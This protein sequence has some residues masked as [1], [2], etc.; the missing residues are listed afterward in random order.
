MMHLM[1]RI[2]ER[3]R[4]CSVALALAATASLLMLTAAA[5]AATI[6]V[7]N[8]AELEAAVTTA[9][10]NAQ[11]N[12]IELA[13]GS[14]L[15]GK[16]LVLTDT[17][18]TQT[19]AGPAGTV[20]VATASA[21]LNGGNVAPVSGVSEQEFFAVKAG[22]TLLLK[23]VV[24]TTAGGG[25]SPAIDDFGTM[26]VEN[27]T[28]DGNTGTQILVESGATANLTNS[29][30]SDGHELGLADEGTA[31]LLNVTA[32]KNTGGGVGGSGTLTLKNS[33]VALNGT[34]AQCGTETITNDHSLSSDA[35]CGGE[36]QFQ[37]KTP[38][39]QSLLQ[40]DGGSTTLYSE[41]AGSPTIDAGD[42]AACPTTDQRGY[43][44]PDA[45]G[46]SAPCDIGADEYSAE[47]PSIKVPAEIVKPATSSA[48]AE[49]TYAVEATDAGSLVKT[50]T[51]TPASGSTFKAGTT[52][53][54]CNAVDGHENKSTASFNVKVT[55]P[56]HLLTV[57]VT[58]E[59]TVTSTPAGIECGQTHTTCSAEFEEVPVTLTPAP[60]TGYTVAWSG[61]CSGTGSCSF[62]PMTAAE[63]V[64]ATFNAGPVNTSVPVISGSPYN[65]QTLK[66]TNGT[67]T[68]SPT[69]F[70]YQWEDCNETGAECSSIAGAN[71]VEYTLTSA[72]IGHT[73]RV[74][75][76]AINSGGE[77]TPAESA[78]TAVV[79]ASVAPTVEGKVPFTQTLASTCSTVVVGPFIPGKPAE[80]AN[81]CGLTATS[82]A[83][84]SKLV[85]E[86]TSATDTGHLV[87]VYSHGPFKETYEL[88]DALEANA[89]STQGG[90][91]GAL[92]S[93]EHPVTLLTYAKPFAEDAV[94]VK[95]NQKI[96][97]H[98]H[99]H[100]GTYAKTIV[101]TLST[102]TP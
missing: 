24:L 2:L 58:G 73:V 99:L 80:Y 89:T 54:A 14:Y 84:E 11:A 31:T 45:F 3:R 52:K 56:K 8:T 90:A 79:T 41:K 55:T 46:G 70:K 38:L 23:H 92:T 17:S 95:F 59:G 1:H 13:S 39:L 87:Q 67:W 77:S 48:G 21:V 74:L 16:S 64:T 93:L 43:P 12:T 33:I 44:R 96:G 42:P 53:V 37:N 100:T 101:V 27:A 66:T 19:I 47:T 81:T 30:L 71:G 62:N 97:L 72:D 88:P 50:L 102:T 18:G 75:V 83:A 35:T 22:V 4:T 34:G 78:A 36:A 76:V 26:D 91:P 25:G 10:G 51:C 15:P 98:D 82:T 20:G 40:N 60:A 28:I 7:K 85:A 49:V 69:S 65:G 32:V 6:V 9:N 29:T 86:D 68:G 61:A 5:N 63:S 94:T 57:T